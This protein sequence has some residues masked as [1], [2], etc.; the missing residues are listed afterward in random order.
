[1]RAAQ[2][3]RWAF[4]LRFEAQCRFKFGNAF[5]RFA[6]GEQGQPQIVVS[7]G[8]VRIHPE[9]FGKLLDSLW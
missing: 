8:I 9:R 3:V 6:G 1:M 4:Q 2:I 7:F 5:S